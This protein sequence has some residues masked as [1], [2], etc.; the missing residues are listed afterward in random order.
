M[1]MISA[2]LPRGRIQRFDSI[3]ALLIVGIL[4]IA[5]LTGLALGLGIYVLAI[6]VVVALPAAFLFMRPDICLVAVAGLTLVISGLLKSFLGIGQLQWLISALG[7]TLLLI[8]LAKVFFS[9]RG[10]LGGEAGGIAILL[11]L[12]WVIIVFA[13]VANLVPV[14]D[15]FVGIRIFL[16]FLGVFAYV[17]YCR[18][19][20][21]LLRAVFLSLM[22][23]TS[24]QWVFCIYQKF[25]VV[26]QRIAGGYPGSPWDSIVGTFGG[27][28]FG[29]GES[30][31][32]G[33]FLA[34]V[35]II[36]ASLHKEKMLG[37][38]AFGAIVIFGLAAMALSESK[39]VVLLLPLGALIVYRDYIV[40]RP[41]R[42][43][44]GAFVMIG[45][46]VALLAGYHY[47]YW[48]TDNNQGLVDAIV[49]RLGYSFDPNFRVTTASLGRV[50]SLVFWWNSHSMM[51]NPLNLLIGHGLAS[52]VGVS[53]LIGMGTAVQKYG[54]MLDTT[55]A[56]KIL[57]ET[58]LLGFLVFQSVFVVGFLRAQQLSQ[59]KSIP[60]W[61]RAVLT[62]AQAAMVIMFLSVFYEQTSAGS[63]PMQFLCMFFLGYIVYWWRESN[64]GEKR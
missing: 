49:K 16:P 13:S 33:V 26:P 36:A 9:R 12:W 24:V 18:P 19:P 52:A 46:V 41:I 37:K 22:A 6:P 55:G 25:V 15:W 35:L 64:S 40:R 28:K 20:E 23:I 21:R 7:A 48:Q 44:M 47:M 58:G 1:G 8:S 14:L 54:Y 29:G 43:F 3:G 39:V 42:F 38:L 45:L 50:G 60:P 61:H 2:A 59:H 4:L 53:S 51:D 57:W 11:V 62:S 34:I 32:L 27:E 63:P 56:V 30:G 10:D 17:A 5:V 31:S